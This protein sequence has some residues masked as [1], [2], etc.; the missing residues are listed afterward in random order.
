MANQYSPQPPERAIAV[1]LLSRGQVTV[2]EIANFYGLSRQLVQ[3]WAADIDVA[4][5]RAAWIAR[6]VVQINR[7][8]RRRLP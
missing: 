3:Q 6:K 5:A 4:G 1:K 2:A 8:A 7:R